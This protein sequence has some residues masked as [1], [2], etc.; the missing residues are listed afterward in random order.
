L[1][2]PL[3]QSGFSKSTVPRAV[4]EHFYFEVLAEQIQHVDL[5]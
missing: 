3:L 1:E 2:P 5:L 4:L